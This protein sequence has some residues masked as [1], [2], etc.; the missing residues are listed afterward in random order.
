L[1]AESDLVL[2][3]TD[4]GVLT[5]TLNLSNRRP[6]TYPLGIRKPMIAAIKFEDL[7]GS[8]RVHGDHGY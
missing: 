1:T 6:Q 4:A 7:D 2:A 3:S 5:L 8:F